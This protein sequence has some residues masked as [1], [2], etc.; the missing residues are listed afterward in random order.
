MRFVRRATDAEWFSSRLS[1]VAT[2]LVFCVVAAHFGFSSGMKRGWREDE[3]LKIAETHY[4]RLF[5]SGDLT[6]PEWVSDRLKLVNPPVGKYV[7][8]I[9]GIV[10]GSELPD[11][12][13]VVW[14]ADFPFSIPPE[15]REALFQSLLGAA[16]WVSVLATATIAAFLFWT[17]GRIAGPV[18]AIVAP[19]LYLRSPLVIKLSTQAIFDALQSAFVIGIPLILVVLVRREEN[20]RRDVA[21]AAALGI[22]GALAFQT[23]LNGVL[24]FAAAVVVVSLAT[25]A[26]R[27]RVILAITLVAFSAVSL[28][29]NPYYWTAIRPTDTTARDP[30]SEMVLPMRIA[31]R[32]RGQVSEA[33]R[34]VERNTDAH[35]ATIPERA[36]FVFS[37]TRRRIA[38]I[39]TLLGFAIAVVLA[40][41]RRDD[42][43]LRVVVLFAVL[44]TLFVT[45][46]L[47]LSWTRYVDITLAPLALA[48]GCGFGLVVRQWSAAR[49]SSRTVE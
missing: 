22:L 42:R 41:R 37:V 32:I 36:K 9:A 21:L 17:A 47:P 30:A 26:K 31:S 23:R 3:A 34:Q 40:V 11:S 38:G 29:V 19:L 4:A 18:A 16:R 6:A 48:A 25:R 39:L 1:V 46:W 10:S 35:L 45:A 28:A 24:P 8:G 15:G 20:G 12:L 44:N 13:D 14:I 27:R 49:L 7:Y 5:F 2:I 33:E 43:G